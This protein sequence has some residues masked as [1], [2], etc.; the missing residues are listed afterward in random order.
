MTGEVLEVD[1]PR[2]IVF[3]YGYPGGAPF[4]ADSSRVTIEL[5]EDRHGTRLHLRHAFRDVE[6]REHHEQGWRYQL[7]VFSNV[8][9]DQVFARIS[10]ERVDG[11]FAAW[12]EPDAARR[13]ALL[14][15]HV[16]AYVRFHDR[17]SLVEGRADLDP[18]LA[19]VHVFMPGTKLERQGEPRQCQ[20]TVLADWIARR[21]DGSEMGRGTNVFG[22]DPDGRIAE[23]AGIWGGR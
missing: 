18:H 2:R 16:S 20:G 17:F 21:G 23:V 5:E 6:A 19:A 9:A 14:D 4:P 10:A 3:S 22:L 1:P 8:V 12:S 11:W 13:A 7:A 15:A